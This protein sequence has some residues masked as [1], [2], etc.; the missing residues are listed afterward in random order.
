[1]TLSPALSMAA[2]D[3]FREELR[4]QSEI[5]DREKWQRICLT[6]FAFG[7]CGIYVD[8]VLLAGLAC[9][10]GACEYANLRMLRG[11]DPLSQPGLYRATLLLV[12]VVEGSLAIA[13]GLVWQSQ[14]Q[15]AGP[16]AV[17][18]VMSTALHL[19][20]VRSVHL[21]YGLAGLATL[22]ATSFAANVMHWLPEGSLPGFCIST[23][24]IVGGLGYAYVAMLSN[25]QLHRATADGQ[26]A[27]RAADDA[28]SRFLAEMSH[29][30]RTPLNAIIGLGQIEAGA[31]TN[32]ASRTRL[33]TLVASARGLA[34]VLDDVLDL[35]AITDGRL[36][37]RPRPVD[38]RAELQ[39]VVATFSHQTTALNLSLD[40]D[41]DRDMPARLVLDPQRLRQCLINLVS[42]AIKHVTKGGIRLSA[43]VDGHLLQI[44]VADTGPGI[45]AA[46]RE[47]VFEP[48]RKLSPTSP[49]TGLGLA[50]SRSL[51][52]QMHG[53]LILLPTARGATFR[54]TALALPAAEEATSRV[55]S[56]PDLAG[57]TILV[58][59]DIATNRMVATIAL[60][61]LSARV[62]E[63][64]GGRQALDVLARDR[65]DLVLLDMNMPDLDG[66]ATF[67]A[68]RTM[69]GASARVPVVAMT[70]D[71]MPAQK[72]MIEAQGLDGYLPKPLSLDD[73]HRELFRHLSG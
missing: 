50:I 71:A 53:D 25:H 39:S 4:R 37:L 12:V 56:P 30:L 15:Y 1:M 20:T 8:P 7:L 52:R 60:Q 16:L 36:V 38:V 46:L 17:G 58:V 27:A 6:L 54:L 44:D 43:R 13:G 70:A 32:P 33:D 41:F 67:R 45:P 23:A 72:A 51:A 31:A 34:V 26:A 61:R 65:V 10:Y 55:V 63:A 11:L 66:F 73:L 18:I 40:L 62:I 19:A 5:L 49:G 68:I 24:G 28:K 42:N 69:Q 48:F 47:A 2:P 35:S 29:E 14:D 22:A 64:D 21:P 9:V 59:D 3:Q 57:R